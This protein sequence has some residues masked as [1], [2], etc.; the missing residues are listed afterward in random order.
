M[1]FTECW[2]PSE[3]LFLFLSAVF[4]CIACVV[5]FGRRMQLAIDFNDDGLIPLTIPLIL[6]TILIPLTTLLIPFTM[7]TP[8]ITLTTHHVS[9]KHRTKKRFIQLLLSDMRPLKRM[10]SSPPRAACTTPVFSCNYVNNPF[11][12]AFLLFILAL[13]VCMSQ[14]HTLAR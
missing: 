12:D 11:N 6:L 13:L 3:L 8:P 10:P 2:L 14:L 9:P 5:L 4:V 7:P 1:L